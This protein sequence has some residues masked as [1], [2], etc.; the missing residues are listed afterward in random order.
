MK[1]LESDYLRSPLTKL[2]KMHEQS[3]MKAA[4][5]ATFLNMKIK[6]FIFVVMFFFFLAEK[7]TIGDKIFKLKYPKNSKELILPPTLVNLLKRGDIP[8]LNETEINEVLP[9]LENLLLKNKAL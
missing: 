3:L 6:L 4:T 1:M 8:E 2:N 7:V 5:E 9:D